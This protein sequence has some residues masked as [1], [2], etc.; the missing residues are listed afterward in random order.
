MWGLQIFG[1]LPSWLHTHTHTHYIQIHTHTT[2]LDIC[3]PNSVL[4]FCDNAAGFFFVCLF[5]FFRVLNPFLQTGASFVLKVLK[6]C[7][8]YPGSCP[9]LYSLSFTIYRY[10]YLF[11]SSVPWRNC[12]CMFLCVC[13]WFIFVVLLGEISNQKS[14]NV[15]LDLFSKWISELSK[16]IAT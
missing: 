7:L 11:Y 10:V 16:W 12:V 14:Q 2:S 9:S 15:C 4:W 8:T 3:D 5:V 13:V 6:A 1:S